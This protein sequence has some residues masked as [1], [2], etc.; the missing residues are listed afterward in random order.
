M[1]CAIMQP[2]YLPWPG[3]FNLMARAR[4]FVF[5]DDVQFERS[6]WQSRNRI[7]TRNGP[8][9][10]S[11]TTRRVTLHTQIRDIEVNE[12]LDWRRKHVET[13]RQ[14]YAHH[15]H[16]DCLEGLLSIL[17]DRSVTRLADIN[18]AIIRHWAACLSLEPVFL[19]SSELNVDGKRSDRL[20]NICAALKAAVYYS[21]KGAREYLEEDRALE[22]AG[23]RIVFQD[24]TVPPYPQLK[25]EEFVPQLSL[26]DAAANLGWAGA[27]EIVMSGLQPAGAG[28]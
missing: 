14:A 23:I 25:S 4:Q 11:V 21:P 17:Q 5:L 26:L 20:V 8:V 13:I 18:I 28:A 15:P 12:S 24:Y 1:S 19:R 16:R 22:K 2:T 27:R 6:T 3:Y 9:W 7:L 10:L